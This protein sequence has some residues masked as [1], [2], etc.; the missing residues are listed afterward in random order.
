MSEDWSYLCILSL[1]WLQ[2]PRSLGQDDE[3]IMLF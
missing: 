1:F 2:D 3:V